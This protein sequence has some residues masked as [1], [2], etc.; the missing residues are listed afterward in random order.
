[1]H[2]EV[3]MVLGGIV[4]VVLVAAATA[5]TLVGVEAAAAAAVGVESEVETVAA[6]MGSVVWV[7]ALTAERAVAETVPE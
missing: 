7:V 5:V 6:A 4:A 1:M 3:C 2:L